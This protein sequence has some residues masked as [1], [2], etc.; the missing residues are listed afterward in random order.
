MR[1]LQLIKGQLASISEYL[2]AKSTNAPNDQTIAPTA[3]GSSNIFTY[4][5]VSGSIP[6]TVPNPSQ[7]SISNKF[8]HSTLD[9]NLRTAVL[10]AV[11]SELQL[12]SQRSNNIVVTGLPIS[13]IAPDSDQFQELCRSELDVYPKIRTT[14]R[15][16]EPADGK[17][18]PLLVCLESPEE[19]GRMMA[20]AREL[21]NSSSRNVRE[22]IF[23]NR[24]LTKAEAAAE[25]YKRE[26]RRRKEQSSLNSVHLSTPT[27]MV[28][29][30]TLLP[31]SYPMSSI[32]VPPPLPSPPPFHQ[33]ATA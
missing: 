23:I 15:L 17:I 24:H 16:G 6:T 9:K 11:H 32:V 26:E 4:A 19:V 20:V 30:V 25:F 28:D 21:R 29:T 31:S 5:Q 7:P 14:I 8:T 22:R 10:T 1:E 2:H 13:N 3:I 27:G 18:Q 12:K 33:P